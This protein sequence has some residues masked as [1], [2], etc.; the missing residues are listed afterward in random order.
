MNET[1]KMLVVLTAICLLSSFALTALNQGLADRIAQQEEF[2]VRGPAVMDVFAG[3]PNDPLADAFTIDVEGTS[4]RLYPWIE[5][6][7]CQAVAMETAGAG[8]YGGDVK[9]MTAIN[10]ISGELLGVRVTSHSET[11]G[12]G[13]RVAD[14]SYLRSYAGLSITGTTFALQSG[15]GDIAAVSG[16]TR[17]S[18]AVADGVRQAV[19]FVTQH[20]GDIPRWV[21]EN[22]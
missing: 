15:G 19:E 2:F 21:T 9:V 22:R 4:W 8:G 11:P 16:A 12:V 18:T 20:Q 10:F 7:E 5:D 14:P 6:G 17:T 13:T 3:V 1:V